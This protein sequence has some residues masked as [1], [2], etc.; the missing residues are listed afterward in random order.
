MPK[1]SLILAGIVAIAMVFVAV[2]ARGYCEDDEVLVRRVPPYD[3]CMP[4]K[5]VEDCRT[6]GG[7]LAHCLNVGCVR[8]AGIQ[9]A[10]GIGRCKS[11]SETCLADRG[12]SSALIGVIT[13]C[14]IATFGEGIAPCLVAVGAGG[15]AYD[16]SVASCKIK[17]GACVDPQRE[18]HKRFEAICKQPINLR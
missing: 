12:V 2:P 18:T 1:A 11:E 17:Y 9:L 7:N 10:D 14:F 13:V 16:E 6:K 4:K 3:Y 5:V 15:F 8:N